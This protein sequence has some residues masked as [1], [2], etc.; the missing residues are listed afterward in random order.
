MGS[1]WTKVLGKEVDPAVR[2][3]SLKIIFLFGLVSL[4]GDIIYEGAR[5]VNGQYLKTLGANA[6]VVGFIAGLGEFVGY[7]VRFFSGY[8][9]DKSK[10]YWVFTFVGYGMLASVPLLAL[11]G[12]W[13]S[14]AMFMVMERLGK[15][16]R[17]P[18]KDTILSRAVT[19]VGTGFGFALHEVMD[20]I[21][22]LSGPL[23]FT[24]FFIL[25]GRGVRTVADY[26]QGYGFLWVPYVILMLCV[27][28]AYC[29][30]RDDSGLEEMPEK[31][32][33]AERLSPV[34]WMYSLFT[35]VVTLGFVSFVLV[36]YHFKVRG[37]FTDAQIPALYALAMAVDAVAAV[38][39]GRLYDKSKYKS[40]LRHGGLRLLLV[41]PAF[42]LFIPVLVFSLSRQLA[43]LGV[44]IWGVVMGCHETI[45]K[46]AIADI[47]S[48][49]KRG[50][51]YGV[52]NA[53]YGLAFFIGS[54]L[55]G[56]LYEHSLK[57]LM[58]VFV[59]IEVSAV[60][61]FFKITSLVV[62]RNAV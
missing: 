53:A 9:S 46:S 20:Q 28:G 17:S 62:R 45:M 12:I 6:A 61:I 49:A 7:A 59:V 34:F 60:P 30:M 37:L 19:P 15:A 16:L 42:S 1:F 3:K 36:G 55:A 24:G 8:F 58:I 39:T 52:F 26:Q 25:L 22:A 27:F 18:A 56:A 29:V 44:V 57:F 43:V 54:A 35:F 11:T 4:F 13:Q 38:V 14:A 21:G 50:T 47:T 33:P 2:K 41:I 23:V 10:A 51:G 31:S 5:S 48:L 40:G 32:R